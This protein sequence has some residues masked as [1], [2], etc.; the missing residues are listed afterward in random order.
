M[1]E[2]KLNNTKFYT[3]SWCIVNLDFFQAQVGMSHRYLRNVTHLAQRKSCRA[4][5]HTAL[6]TPPC[7]TNIN[8]LCMWSCRP[9]SFLR[10]TKHSLIS[11]TAALRSPTS[12][13]KNRWRA[14]M[15]LFPA[16]LYSL[17]F[18]FLHLLDIHPKHA[19]F[20]E[21]PWIAVEEIERVRGNLSPYRN[22]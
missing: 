7:V 15:K 20:I 9:L 12:I 1:N 18:P 19:Q 14:L 2:K 8:T 17:S 10:W 21:Q 13:Y 22:L 3:T 11:S 4:T 6:L 5:L 16:Y